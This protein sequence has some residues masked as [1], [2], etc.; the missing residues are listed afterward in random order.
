M[1]RP[2]IAT[3]IIGIFAV[4]AVS[5]LQLV[6]QLRDFESRAADYM[7]RSASTT[8]NLPTQLQYVIMSIL[9]FGI[10]ALTVTSVRRGRLGL[11][12]L[13]LLIELAAVTWICGLYGIFFQPFPSMLAV[14]LAFVAADRYTA[15]AQRGRAV[16]ARAFFTDRLSKEQVQRVVSGDIDFDP[17]A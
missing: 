4:V 13:G 5:A 2:L 12:V 1:K 16:T 7:S 6:P 9:A 11:I 14:A 3:L 17:E 10:A 8:E 15:I